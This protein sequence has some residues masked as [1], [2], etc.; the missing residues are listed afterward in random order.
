MQFIYSG[1]RG[2]VMFEKTKKK[3]IHFNTSG[4]IAEDFLASKK[5]KCAMLRTLIRLCFFCHLIGGIA[6]SAAGYVFDRNNFIAL[7]VCA[8]IETVIAFFAAGGEMT[9]KA[10]LVGIDIILSAAGTIKAVLS[11]EGERVLYFVY[12]GA[13]FIG[14]IM[15]FV[16][17]IAAHLRDYLQD[18]PAEKLKTEDVTPLEIKDEELPSFEL[19]MSIINS[20]EN[21]KRPP[22]VQ[23]NVGEM[24]ELAGKL[25][26][27]LNGDMKGG[28]FNP[29]I[30]VEIDIDSSDNPEQ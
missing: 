6:C 4:N 7:V 24:R 11:S 3:L 15:A 30:R 13:A 8:V 19:R 21:K 26:T 5:K 14:V 10:S 23:Q 22:A 12:G 29:D 28:G 16:G 25:N 2:F 17:M 20:I 1:K 18:F 27:I 9:T